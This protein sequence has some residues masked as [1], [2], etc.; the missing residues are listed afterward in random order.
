MELRPGEAGRLGGEIGR[1]LQE[2]RGFGGARRLSADERLTGGGREQQAAQ[3]ASRALMGQ[4]CCAGET[5]G[6]GR[7]KLAR[8]AD[9]WRVISR[10]RG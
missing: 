3:R 4:K 1:A 2:S 7:V 9:R 10:G 6:R 5:T 8:H